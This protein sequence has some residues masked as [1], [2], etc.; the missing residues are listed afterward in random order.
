MIPVT[1]YSQVLGSVIAVHRQEAGLRPGEV[2]VRLGISP[3]HYADLERGRWACPVGELERICAA[4]AVTPRHLLHHADGLSEG[5]RRKG[6]DVLDVPQPAG[7]S[8]IWAWFG[9]VL[10]ALAG[11]FAL[12]VRR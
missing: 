8:R 10:G 4:L 1:T 7:V 11:G 12:G 2:A 6:V 9:G 5:L 3:T